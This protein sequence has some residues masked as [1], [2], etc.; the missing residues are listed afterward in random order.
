MIRVPVLVRMRMLR[1]ESS[2]SFL[3]SSMLMSLDI[4]SLLSFQVTGFRVQGSGK[5]QV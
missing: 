3:K 4:G 1:R 5:K 2:C